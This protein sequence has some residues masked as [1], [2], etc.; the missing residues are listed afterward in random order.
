[1][2]TACSPS[3]HSGPVLDAPTVAATAVTACNTGA[4][5]PTVHTM[6][7]ANFRAAQ[8]RHFLAAVVA[9]T[10]AA[11]LLPL[12]LPAAGSPWHS[13]GLAFGIW[14]VMWF[15]VGG[16][17]VSVG[18]HRCFSHRSFEAKR[19]LRW[20]LGVLGAMAAQ[21][22]AVY[23]V[24]LHRMHHA[25]S[26]LPGDPHSPRQ[27]AR[28]GQSR[29]RAAFNGHIGWVWSHDLP[30][31]TRYARELLTDPLVRRL[32]RGYGACVALGL[33]IPALVGALTLQ[34]SHGLLAGALFGAYWG[35]V[36]RIALGHHIIWSIN[37]W[38]HLGGRRPHNTAEGSGNVAALALLSWGESWHNNHHAK[39]TAARFGQG[40]WQ[41]DIG[42]WVVQF[43]VLMGWAKLRTAGDAA[44]R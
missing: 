1:M 3:G 40:L 25:A 30:K 22:S 5:A 2:S 17:G 7:A 31:P 10:L 20:V 27:R 12:M 41:P 42:W 23:W 35:G 19:P 29:W 15:L 8:R 33:L 32:T 6:P 26:D 4:A 36:V 9:P 11:L 18:L 16:V 43:F 14:A 44:Q 21:G 13:P 39:P 37:S 34:A 38:C 24:S 28:P